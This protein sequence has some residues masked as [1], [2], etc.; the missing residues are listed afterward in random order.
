MSS[1]YQISTE[2]NGVFEVPAGGI[3]TALS[4]KLVGRGAPGY[5][6]AYAENT[7]KALSNHAST[8]ANRPLTPLIGQLWYNSTIH[9]LMHF[10]G[11]GS[12]GADSTGWATVVST[13]SGLGSLSSTITG[14]VSL[15]ADTVPTADNTVTVGSGSARFKKVFAVTFDGEA[16]SADYADVA[17]RY[18][19]DA[20]LAAGDVVELGGAKEVTKST[21]AYSQT[22]FGV[23][24]TNPAFMMNKAAGSDTTHPYIAMVGRVPVKVLGPVTKGQRLVSSDTP[25]VARA[26]DV[27]AGLNVYMVIGRALESKTS[28][29]VGLIEAVLGAK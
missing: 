21:S 17:E 8:A 13:A 19:A 4:L 20:P 23:V 24:S 9:A 1:N 7:I 29:G 12:T 16:T 25:G 18:E 11:V 6:L 26:V 22:V 5:G 10:V 2:L 28:D 14:F 3:S 27:S 15:S